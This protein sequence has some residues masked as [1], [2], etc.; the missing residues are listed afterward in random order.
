MNNNQ[1]TNP[2]MISESTLWEELDDKKQEQIKGGDVVVDLKV[3]DVL[4]L[5]IKVIPPFN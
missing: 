1:T 2:L 4:D 5:L 3:K